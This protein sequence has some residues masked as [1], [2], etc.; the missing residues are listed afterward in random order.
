MATAA[1]A[2]ELTLLQR[3]QAHKFYI[4]G[5]VLLLVG[6]GLIVL[7]YTVQAVQNIKEV[8]SA[9]GGAMIGSGSS[10]LLDAY[11]KGETNSAIDRNNQHLLQETRNALAQH[12]QQ[13]ITEIAETSRR[14]Q[15]HERQFGRL[16]VLA[17]AKNRNYSDVIR[18]AETLNLVFNDMRTWIGLHQHKEALR[19]R[20]RDRKT[21]HIYLLHPK[22]E[23][24]NYIT[25]I[26]NKEPMEQIGD[27]EYAVRSICDGLWNAAGDHFTI[28]GHHKFNTYTIV[29]TE[30]K[31]WAVYYPISHRYNKDVVW[32]HEIGDGSD[33]IYNNFFEDIQQLRR[34]SLN[35]TDHDLIKLW[36]PKST[37]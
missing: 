34:Q 12:R 7:A 23:W 36:A 29:M 6:G 3:L 35:I 32:T 14:T 17:P 10:M 13:I 1:P 8:L 15:E 5:L 25:R 4:F 30:Q 21:T 26:S 31:C 16:D 24:I 9:V 19:E 33:N 22:S 18:K 20:L 28:T 2:N 11:S 27:I 37:K